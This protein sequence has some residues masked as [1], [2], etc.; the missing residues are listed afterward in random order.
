M[1]KLVVIGNNVGLIFMCPCM[2]AACVFVRDS[3]HLRLDDDDDRVY[4][5]LFSSLE[6][7][8]CT[9]V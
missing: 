7:T 8:D 4:I 5:A 2:Y 6:Q 9:R 1:P 3:L